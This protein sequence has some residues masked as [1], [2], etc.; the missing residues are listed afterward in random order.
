MKVDLE[1]WGGVS[2]SE[3]IR[4]SHE[5]FVVMDEDGIVTAW[6]DAATR[7]FGF[8]ADAAIGSRLSELIIP[9]RYRA[10]HERGLRT[11]LETGVGPV[12]G[13]TIEI[14]GQDIDGRAVPV[15]LTINAT[16]R[17]GRTRFHAFLNEVTHARRTERFLRA[18]ARI[19]WK[20]AEGP[21]G[22]S[23]DD[24]LAG[25]GEEMVFSVGLAWLPDGAG[26][27]R[28]AARWTPSEGAV[29][30]ARDSEHFAFARGEGMP[31]KTWMEGRASWR[32]DLDS[33]ETYA[34]RPSA[35]RLGFRSGL[36]VPLGR[37]DGCRGVLEF[38][39]TEWRN[40]GD[41]LLERFSRLGD[42]LDRH[43]APR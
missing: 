11:Y 36:F 33:E 8:A 15:E 6:N 31:G 5:A 16:A 32:P 20:C 10:L 43:V 12:L 7:M 26:A 35:H 1:D 40:A 28:L 4:I 3:V 29:T 22:I 21:A 42:H 19:A 41:D 27:L 14:E 25:I 24:V 37:G 34:R 9:E 39:T 30:F 13:T 2:P 18:D 23:L 38:L 17:D